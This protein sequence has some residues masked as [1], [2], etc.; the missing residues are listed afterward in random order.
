MKKEYLKYAVWRVKRGKLLTL[1]CSEVNLT[2]LPRYTSWID[3]TAATHI[4]VSMQACL[5]TDSQM[6]VNDSSLWATTNQLQ[7]RL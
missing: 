5:T 2:S 1:V 6:M 7:L 3:S 4:S